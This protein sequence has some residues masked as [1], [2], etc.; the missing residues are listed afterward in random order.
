MD[1][2]RYRNHVQNVLGVT[3]PNVASGAELVALIKTI[4]VPD[5]EAG[6]GWES[7]P[8]FPGLCRS[9]GT[10]GER[11]ADDLRAA[12][13]TIATIRKSPSSSRRS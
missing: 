2:L 9:S 3:L 7:K 1:A 6:N 5:F 8:P 4:P 11:L 12:G 13:C 10:D